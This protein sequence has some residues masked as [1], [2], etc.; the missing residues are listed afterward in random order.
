MDDTLYGSLQSEKIAEDRKIALE[1]VSEIN[2]FGISDRQ[3]WMIIHL[4][5]LELENVE[6]MKEMVSFIKSK[7]EKD[8]FVSKIYSPDEDNWVEEEVKE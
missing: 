2:K 8:I 4:L 6:D 3:R 1:V 7:K 5:S